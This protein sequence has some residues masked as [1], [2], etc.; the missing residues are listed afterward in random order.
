MFPKGFPFSTF[1]EAS[2][3]YATPVD[4]DEPIALASRS[5]EPIFLADVRGGPEMDR[6]RDLVEQYRIRSV[7]FVPTIG[8]VLE[9]G[10]T[11]GDDSAE[12]ADGMPDASTTD[13]PTAELREA[14]DVDGAVYVI[15]W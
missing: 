15:F 8:G 2:R 10:T 5:G 6:R 7:C 3:N 11:D 13:L 4:S 9:L 1:P 12:W 14:F